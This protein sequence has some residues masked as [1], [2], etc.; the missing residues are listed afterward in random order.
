M[1]VLGGHDCESTLFWFIFGLEAKS[2]VWKGY[3]LEHHD[4]VKRVE[5]RWGEEDYGYLSS[6]PWCEKGMLRKLCKN[7]LRVFGAIK[8]RA[9]VHCFWLVKPLRFISGVRSCSHVKISQDRCGKHRICV[10][11]FDLTV[12][13]CSLLIVYWWRGALSPNWTELWH[14]ACTKSIVLQFHP[15]WTLSNF[16]NVYV[17]PLTFKNQNF[18]HI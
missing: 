18:T 5:C 2:S 13:I 14:Y 11:G 9:C 10:R 7:A 16:T 4:S 12:T 8:E 17:V 3:I 6:S 1:G 15:I